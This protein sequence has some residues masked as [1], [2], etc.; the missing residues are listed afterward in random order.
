M[1]FNPNAFDAEV[2]FLKRVAV[3]A[4][5]LAL[6]YQ[7]KGISAETKD[8]DSPVTAAD[9]ACEKMLVDEIGRQFPDDGIFGEEGANKESKSGRRWIIDPIDGTKDFVRGLPVWA[10][11]IGLEQ[12]GQVVA[13][14][15]NC[16]TQNTLSWASKGGGSFTN[17]VR[18]QVSSVNDITRAVVFFNGFHKYNVAAMGQPLL[19][20]ITQVWS[21]RGFGGAMD[22]LFLAMGRADVWIEPKAKAWD[23]APLKIIVE[24]AGGRFSSFAGENSI[25]GGNGYAYTPGL[26]SAVKD[27]F[28]SL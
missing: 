23:F 17:G 18:N 28:G 1:G 7:R 24:E 15:A 8:D 6:D 13:G 22:A 21:V 9:K 14:V 4:G 16:P 26:E 2:E 20:W 11:L 27:L 5:T 10:N 25:Y 19:D 3:E 12:A